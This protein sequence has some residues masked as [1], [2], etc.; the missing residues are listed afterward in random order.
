MKIKAESRMVTLTGEDYKTG[1]GK[2]ITLGMVLAEGLA[3][4][5]AGGK[6]KS[7]TLAS[8]LY[9]GVDVEVDAADMVLIKKAVEECKTYNNLILGQA[10]L[11]LE[12][13]K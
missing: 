6:M 4:S 2:E 5:E 13:A 3:S 1:D 11:M 9:S 10:L 8:K 7:Y 12:E